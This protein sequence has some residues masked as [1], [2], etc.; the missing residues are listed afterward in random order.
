MDVLPGNPVPGVR[1][2]GPILASVDHRVRLVM[3]QSAGLQQVG[4]ERLS[5]LDA[6]RWLSAPRTGVP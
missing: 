4:V 1:K 2:E 5:L 6:L 3:G